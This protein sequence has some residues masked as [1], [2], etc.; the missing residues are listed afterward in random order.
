M[1]NDSNYK[2]KRDW[3]KNVRQQKIQERKDKLSKEKEKKELSEFEKMKLMMLSAADEYQELRN[4]YETEFGEQW[5]PV[6]KTS[7]PTGDNNN[8]TSTTANSSP[9]KVFTFDNVDIEKNNKNNNNAE[10]QEKQ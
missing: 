2:K 9:T 10:N 7:I 8:E 4:E 1:K 6:H 3:K 5:S